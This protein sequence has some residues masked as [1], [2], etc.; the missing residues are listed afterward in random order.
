[1]ETAK[2]LIVDDEKDIRASLTDFLSP[3]I[4]CEIFQAENAYEAIEKIKNEPV[5]LILLDINMPGISG[6]DVIKKANEQSNEIAVIVLTKLD[7]SALA[8]QIEELGA[9]Y[10]PKPF[11]LRIVYDEVKKKLETINKYSPRQGN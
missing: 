7:S 4:N 10:I 6:V 9:M 1:M 8:H 11:S 3:R 2:I 5:D